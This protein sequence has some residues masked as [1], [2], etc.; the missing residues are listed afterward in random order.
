MILLC[1]AI[2]SCA[3]RSLSPPVGWRVWRI[4]GLVPGLKYDL[5][6]IENGKLLATTANDVV[7]KPGESCRIKLIA[8]V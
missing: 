3:V 7:L 5:E 8:I 4:E 6:V 1:V 2:F